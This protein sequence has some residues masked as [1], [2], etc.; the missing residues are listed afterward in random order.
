MKTI[1]VRGLKLRI[2]SCQIVVHLVNVEMK[3]IPV[4]GLKLG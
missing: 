1:P 4:R 2:A 3:T